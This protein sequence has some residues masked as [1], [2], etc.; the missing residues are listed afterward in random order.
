ALL[1]YRAHWMSG[2]LAFVDAL[3][4]AVEA[5]GA[6]I[7]PIYCY[8]LKDETAEAAGTPRVF[9]RFLLD[10]AGRPG[11]DAVIN[12]LEFSMAKVAVEGPSLSLGWSVEFL[13]RLNVPILQAVNATSS[14]AQ[15][16][17]ASGGLSPIDTAMNVAMPE[18][19]GRI[20]TVPI[21]FKETLERDP[22]LGAPLQ[23]YVPAADRVDY[24]VCLAARWARL[25]RPPNA[26][27]RVA[28]ILPT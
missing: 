21:S 16:L 17:A 2:N 1:F 23:R 8:S 25:R 19:D 6:S 10:E 24:L 12:T 15:W 26:E 7:L 18:F 3:V 28:L 20:V 14:R 4:R 27:K 22:L 9:R 11:V 13:D 5:Q